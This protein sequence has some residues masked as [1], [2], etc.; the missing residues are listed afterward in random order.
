M[1][2]NMNN[3]S[4]SRREKARIVVFTGKEKTLYTTDRT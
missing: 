2:S 4:F 1:I 3:K